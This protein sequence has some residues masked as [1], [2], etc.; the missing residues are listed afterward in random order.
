MRYYQCKCGT[1]QM[2]DSGYG[3][4]P[5]MGCDECK[6][7]MESHAAAHKTPEPHDLQGRWITV[8][9]K[10]EYVLQCTRWMCRHI[11]EVPKQEWPPL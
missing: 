5:C 1:M 9:G 2:W 8:K 6:T 7:T 10:P 11:E 4:P 3:A